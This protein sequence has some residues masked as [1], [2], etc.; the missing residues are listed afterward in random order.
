MKKTFIGICKTTTSGQS[1]G[2]TLVQISPDIDSSLPSISSHSH[3]WFIQIRRLCSIYNLPSKFFKPKFMS[4]TCPHPLWTT[5]GSNL[6]EINKAFTVSRM[7]S[8][9]YISDC[10][11]RT[12]CNRLGVGIK[13]S[14]GFNNWSEMPMNSLRPE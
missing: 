9:Q 6:F 13:K 12:L 11:C 3:S 2:K 4:L 5:C 8:G 14:L 1:Y 10:H 7:L